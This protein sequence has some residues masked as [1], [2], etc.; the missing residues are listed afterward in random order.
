MYEDDEIYQ[1]GC[2][3]I[4]YQGSGWP[5]ELLLMCAGKKRAYVPKEEKAN[6]KER[7]T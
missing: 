7:T 1:A 5:N 6:G 4:A 3:N 2:I